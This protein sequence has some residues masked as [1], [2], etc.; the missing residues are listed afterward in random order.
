MENSAEKIE[1]EINMS[2]DPVEIEI[3]DDTP[4]ADRKPK[5]D[6]NALLHLLVSI[7]YLFEW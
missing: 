6:E 1:Q 5:R 3:I 2:D 7:F 4:E